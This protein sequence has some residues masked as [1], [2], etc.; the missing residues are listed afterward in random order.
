[1]FGLIKESEFNPHSTDNFIVLDAPVLLQGKEEYE[2]LCP[3][4]KLTGHRDSP[5]HILATALTDKNKGLLDRV[6]QEL[7]TVKQMDV[8]DSVKLDM[9]VSSLDCISQTE[10]DI[11][12]KNL[13]EISEVLFD[14]PFESSQVADP[15]KIDFSNTETSPDANI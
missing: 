8:D 13:M 5:A 11:V 4:N 14:K 1:M 10:R 2:T 6:L 3:I 7:P 15:S 9:L 12:A